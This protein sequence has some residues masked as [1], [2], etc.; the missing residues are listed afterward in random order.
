[1]SSQERMVYSAPPLPTA[2]EPEDEYGDARTAD[3]D[4]QWRQPATYDATAYG[5]TTEARVATLVPQ[6]EERLRRVLSRERPRRL[7]E[8][9]Q[10]QNCT[11]L[12]SGAAAFKCRVC[13]SEEE[14]QSVTGYYNAQKQQVVVCAE[15]EPNEQ[16]IEDTVVHEL[17][18]AYDHCRFGVRVPFVGYQAPWF[19]TCAATA[20]SC[21]AH[22]RPARSRPPLGPTHRVPIATASAGR[23]AGS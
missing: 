8:A 5:S 18:L 16:Q 2:A 20:C 7:L 21:A 13:P 17:I 4:S 10:S 23:C 15:K 11:A 9:I 22:P 1:M 12:K 3:D 6:C 19:L 14:W